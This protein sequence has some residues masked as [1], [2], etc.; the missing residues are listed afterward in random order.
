[1]LWNGGRSSG[2]PG[3]EERPLHRLGFRHRPAW[4]ARSPSMLWIG[5]PSSSALPANTRGRSR[6]GLRGRPGGR[7]PRAC[8]GPAGRRR[9]RPR[10][11]SGLRRPRPSRRSA[12]ASA[13]RSRRSSCA[14]TEGLLLRAR[15]RNSPQDVRGA[16]GSQHG[17]SRRDSRDCRLAP[18]IP[19]RLERRPSVQIHLAL[20]ASLALYGLLLVQ[21]RARMSANLSVPG[22]GPASSHVPRP[23]RRP[24]RR[25]F[26]WPPEA[27]SGILD[28][29]P[30]ALA[31]T[32]CS[33]PPPPR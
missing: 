6:R 11:A 8:C 3:R 16:R 17:L 5:G 27:P 18:W 19:P 2:L 31:V 33:A 10:T 24:V 9:R 30:A 21:I 13:R 7:G 29:P 23:R 12:N 25:S 28:S 1:M 14:E 20:L 22:R 26:P 4:L 32:S 15:T